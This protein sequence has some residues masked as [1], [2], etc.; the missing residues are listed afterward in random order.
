MNS[1][2][3]RLSTQALLG[4]LRVLTGQAADQRGQ[5]DQDDRQHEEQNA[6]PAAEDAPGAEPHHGRVDERHDDTR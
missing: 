3:I 6:A 4:R 2:I 1:T 5:P